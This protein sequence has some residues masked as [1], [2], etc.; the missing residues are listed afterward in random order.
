MSFSIFVAKG[1]PRLVI[2]EG[3]RSYIGMGQGRLI[4]RSGIKSYGFPLEIIILHLPTWY[5]ICLHLCM[6][7]Y[8][9]NARWNWCCRVSYATNTDGVVSD[10]HRSFWCASCRIVMM[11]CQEYLDVIS[12][13]LS[14][15]RETSMTKSYSIRTRLTVWGVRRGTP[16]QDL[17]PF[18]RHTPELQLR[19]L[20]WKVRYVMKTIRQNRIQRRSGS[21]L[22]HQAISRRILTWVGVDYEDVWVVTFDWYEA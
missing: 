18:G 19:T 7:V 2:L 13:S 1:R 12:K 9:S 14:P 20:H 4:N 15:P 5:I 6:H 21:A 11:S 22:L 17:C 10:I 8:I 16:C 3:A